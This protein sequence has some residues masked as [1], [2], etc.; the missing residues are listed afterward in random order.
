MTARREWVR[1]AART[2]LQAA[3]GYAA[4]NAAGVIGGDGAMRSA[5]AALVVASV[6]AGLAAL[7]NIRSGDEIGENG[8]D[9]PADGGEADDE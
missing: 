8:G 5:L 6:A 9:A 1:R 4:A 3:L 2:F 7:M